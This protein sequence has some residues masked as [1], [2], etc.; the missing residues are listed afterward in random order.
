MVST[1]ITRT[2]ECRVPLASRQASLASTYR[3]PSE[4]TA[5]EIRSSPVSIWVPEPRCD[6][7]GGRVE[8][9]DEERVGRDNSP[10]RR[11]TV[12][13]DNVDDVRRRKLGGQILP[14]GGR[15]KLECGLIVVVGRVG[16][17]GLIARC[18][19]ARDHRGFIN[20]NDEASNLGRRGAVASRVDK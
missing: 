12:E 2:H 11:D 8:R 1:S 14:L 15:L 4:R 13:V 10:V 20:C 6:A 17:K 19:C 18:G 3:T 9:V 7:L 16:S 5:E